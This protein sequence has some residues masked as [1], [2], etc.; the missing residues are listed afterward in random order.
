MT[1]NDFITDVAIK[2][3]LSRKNAA[4]AINAFT[5]VVSKCL[6]EGD[7][8]QTGLGIFEVKKRAARNGINPTTKK[9]IA[10]PEKNVVHFKAGAAVRKTINE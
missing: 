7:S 1:K 9:P 8:V 3:G 10:I 6:K 4:A 2:A 5:A